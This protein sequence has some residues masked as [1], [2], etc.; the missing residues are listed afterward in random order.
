MLIRAG[1]ASVD[2]PGLKTSEELM[3]PAYAEPVDARSFFV[4]AT[5]ES[6]LSMAVP[7]FQTSDAVDRAARSEGVKSEPQVETR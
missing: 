1:Q 7:A 3:A 2:E 4:R 5:A 6:A